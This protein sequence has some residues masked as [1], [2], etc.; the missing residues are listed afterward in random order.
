V[1]PFTNSITW[2]FS[3]S[4]VLY[5]MF[6]DG[7]GNFS[8]RVDAVLDDERDMDI[9]PFVELVQARGYQKD[10]AAG[11]STRPKRGATTSYVCSDQLFYQALGFRKAFN[12]E[13]WRRYLD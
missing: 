8:G 2:D 6:V 13:C 5:V 3:Q 10:D 11:C 12:S 4:P 9:P 1:I 7:A